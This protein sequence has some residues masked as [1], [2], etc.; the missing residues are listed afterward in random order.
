MR[1][2]MVFVDGVGIG[3]ADPTRNAFVA[4]PPRA[5]SELLDGALVAEWTE[6]KLA[7]RASLVPL[8]AQLRVPGLPQSGTGQ[9]SLFTGENGAQRFGRHYGPWVPTALRESL[10]RDNLLTRAQAAGWRTAFA[11]AYP[12]ELVEAAHPNG[13]FRPIGP[14]RAG[15]P[16]VAA[17]AGLLV[18][19][20]SALL[21][22]DAISSEITNEA[23]REHLHRHS[24]PR[25]D[26]HMAGANL[27]GI[28]NQHDLTLFAHYN[29]DTA[30]H[31]QDLNEAIR[32]LHLVD[33]FLAGILKALDSN[34]TLV[35]VSDHGNLEDASA[36]HTKNP[37]LGLAVGAGH[38]A[39]AER[40][41]SILDVASA[42][43]SP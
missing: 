11:N 18:R 9:Y 42:L 41:S 1:T 30:G 15:P 10:Q 28:A 40:V 16:L 4:A 5:I 22:G 7:R 37:A 19:H 8:D 6:P 32:A 25:I 38:E 36:G 43:L 27:A 29:T 2:L 31:K 34:I 21:H 26:A 14:L 17:G 35:V 12:E 13:V 33:D 20:T 24:L 3:A 39:F 23:W